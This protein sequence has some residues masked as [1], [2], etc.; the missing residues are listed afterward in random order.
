LWILQL[1]PGWRDEL[2]AYFDAESAVTAARKLVA[3]CHEHNGGRVVSRRDPSVGDDSEGRMKWSNMLR[4]FRRAAAGE[5]NHQFQEAFQV[6]DEAFGPDGW[7]AGQ[8]MISH[9]QLE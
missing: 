8:G 4:V 3:W 9:V 6:L 7:R 1:L 2:R 5:T